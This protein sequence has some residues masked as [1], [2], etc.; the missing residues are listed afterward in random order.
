MKDKLINQRNC[1]EHTN[2]ISVNQ[3]S[4]KITSDN[5]QGINDP[6]KN[7]SINAIKEQVTTIEENSKSVKYNHQ[8]S[9]K[10]KNKA[11]K[12]K[13]EKSHISKS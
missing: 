8:R 9:E 4:T 13:P 10:L 11:S 1:Q 2:R 3:S 6:D 5:T 7:R 12:A